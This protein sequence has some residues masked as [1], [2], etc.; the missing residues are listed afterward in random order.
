MGKHV[1]V[2]AVNEAEARAIGLKELEKIIG[3][4]LQEEELAVE[5]VEEKK[6]F[7]GFKKQVKSFKVS[8]VIKD[9]TRKEEDFLNTTL[10]NIRLDGKFRI[11]V[12]DE[13]IMLKV[14]PPQGQG[15]DVHYQEVKNALEQKEIIGVDWQKVQE[16]IRAAAGEW[17]IIAPRKPELDSDAQATVE[18]SKDKL[19][20]FLSYFPA[21]GGRELTHTDLQNL[22]QEKG[23]VYGLKEEKLKTIIKNRQSVDK[24]LIAEG[25][26]PQP[27]K[28][29]ELVYN[30]EHKTDS[31]GTEREDG[32]IDF[33][34]LGLITNVQPG[35][36]L[37]VKKDP[38]PGVPGKSVTG[39]EIS[40]P[41][42][43]DRKL[44]MGKNVEE[45]DEHTLVSK[46]AGQVVL[47]GEKVHVL[48]VY[49]LNGN[50]DLSTGNID[51]VGNVL[52][53][54]NVTEGFSIRADGNVEV[55]GHVSVADIDAGGDVF[56]HKG[57]IGK[58]KSQIKAGG[59]VRVKFVENA[60]I[61]AGRSIY[62]TDAV[63]HSKLIAGDG[64]EVLEKKGLLVGG[65]ARARTNIEANIIGSSLATNTQVEVG[66]DPGIRARIKEL[67]EQL[68]E[69][70]Q[71][72]L[73]AVKAL[74][75]L[76]RLKEQNNGLPEEK[77]VI[78]YQL[79][80]TREELEKNIEEK[81]EELRYLEE[82]VNVVGGGYVAVHKKVYPGVK[83]L[84]G[85]SQMNV[86]NEIVSGIKFMED[87]GE[88]KKYTIGW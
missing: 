22:L 67:N 55:R 47:E 12:A 52:I 37:V 6:G 87:E 16:V 10:D 61:S 35:D 24:V 49:E 86:H 23:V 78:Y 25:E 30:F 45:K 48:P 53:K 66:I 63:M 72:L 57:F 40:P 26:P 32:S 58:N 19:K 15:K 34:D 80:R 8:L 33:Y 75:I 9:L 64:I 76:E 56:I 4:S 42:P 83:I 71:N 81:Q 82:R 50:V 51:F 74:N 27:G 65:I 1:I 70:K 41:V 36:V 62:V 18:I 13:G 7:L 28:D 44:P 39:E 14:I 11:K 29:A 84:I 60:T 17:E 88:V 46:I 43:R 20:A 68:G 2:D 73:K 54:G 21:H 31:V 77:V 38:E 5:L 79:Q 59:D 69:D 85:N 3:K